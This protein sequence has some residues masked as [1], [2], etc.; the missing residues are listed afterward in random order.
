M[1]AHYFADADAL[2]QQAS[3][4][5]GAEALTRYETAAVSPQQDLMLQH[6]PFCFCISEVQIWYEWHPRC[7]SS[8]EM[9]SDQLNRRYQTNPLTFAAFCNFTVVCPGK[10]GGGVISWGEGGVK[11]LSWGNRGLG[12]SS[13]TFRCDIVTLGSCRHAPLP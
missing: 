4:R 11:G 12:E 7:K 10:E 5:K 1:Q 3:R 6:D 9:Q 13:K 2:H 8:L